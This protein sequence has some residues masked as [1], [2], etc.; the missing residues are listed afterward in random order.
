MKK[1]LT[2]AAL[3]TT[4]L[5]LNGCQSNAISSVIPDRHLAYQKARTTNPLEIPPDIVKSN[6]DRRILDASAGFSGQSLSQY[7]QATSAELVKKDQLA[8]SLKHIHQRGDAAWI[9]IDAKPEKVFA[10]VKR[11]WL[12]S[13]Y[14][15]TKVQ[16]QLGMM[17]TAWLK[18][19]SGLP[20]SGIMRLLS[21]FI[22]GLV[23]K[24]IRDKYRSTI[25][26]DGRYSYVYL[27]QYRASEEAFNRAGKKV[28]ASG[29]DIPDYIWIAGARDPADEIEMLRRLNVF[30]L[31]SQKP[32]AIAS[33]A[34]DQTG[35][36]K[37]TQLR[38]GTPA[39]Q[40]NASFAETWLLLGIAIDRAGFEV[41]SQDRRNG[42]YRFAKITEKRTGFIIKAR[43]R[44][45][46]HYALGIADQGDRQIIVVR[47]YN[48]GRPGAELSRSLLQQ[49]SQAIAF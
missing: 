17:E 36:M 13:G 42:T 48:N 37:L 2:G 6:V 16:P 29:D 31:K 7:Q 39:L 28:R 5:L 18:K 24:G 12:A 22:D 19:S 46:E 47:S 4:A 10:D 26:Y 25:D 41:S 1:C 30:L 14:P 27:T 45:I 23:D 32:A 49:I 40:V 35:N 34:K 43:K 21:P 3:L 15:L 38:D 11:F 9:A 20:T 8:A 44:V 33:E